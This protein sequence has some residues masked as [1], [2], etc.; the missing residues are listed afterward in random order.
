MIKSITAEL[1]EPSIGFW[2]EYA[3]DPHKY[4]GSLEVAGY[5]SFSYIRG[6]M[7]DF[8]L[9]MFTP[10]LFFVDFYGTDRRIKKEKKNQQKSGD[11]GNFSSEIFKLTIY[12]I[13]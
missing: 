9:F 6:R 5:N 10:N 2:Q 1:K 12:H 13:Y 7:D 4:I 8:F 3:Y 11:A